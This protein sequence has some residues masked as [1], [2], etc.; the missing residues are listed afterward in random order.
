MPAEAEPQAAVADDRPPEDSAGER[1]LEL[2]VTVLLALATVATAWAT[3][4]AAQWHGEQAISFSRANAARIE[5]ARASG[6]VNRQVQVDVATFVQWVDAY[7][8]DQT[9]LADFYRERFRDEF[10]PAVEAWIATR[11]LRNPDAPPTPFAMPEYKLDATAQA[12]RLEAEAAAYSEDANADIERANRYVLCVVLFASSLFFA[13]LSMRL[14]TSTG[15]TAVLA[16]GCVLFLGTVI[17][18]V[19]FPVST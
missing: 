16:V 9:M 2:A 15:R 13:G 6:L 1:H 19:T 12:A 18:L 5:S 17:W 10:K 8:Q 7:A 11:P 3:Y 4:Q 14:R